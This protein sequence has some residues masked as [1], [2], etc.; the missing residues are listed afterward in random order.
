MCCKTFDIPEIPKSSGQWCPHVVQAR[1]CGIHEARPQTCR[2][3]FCHWMRNG[4]LGPEWRPDRARF[5]IYIEMEGRRM[6][7][8]PDAGA[9]SA[10]RRAPYL[11]QFRRWAA[12]G[13]DKGHQILVFNGRRATALLPDRDVDLGIVEVG[14]SVVYRSAGGR[15]EV[16]HR[17]AAPRAG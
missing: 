2:L 10:W 14:D 3:F 12:L 6:V 4:A 11:A 1:G 7:V 13:S 9:P 16:E 17:R 8:A 5:L 15:I